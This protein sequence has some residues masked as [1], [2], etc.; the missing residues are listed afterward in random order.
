[1]SERVALIIGNND[2]KPKTAMKLRNAVHDAEDIDKRLRRFGFT[3]KLVTNATYQQM[4]R[5]LKSFQKLLPCAEAALVFFAGHGLQI[6]RE[7]FLI[8]TDSDLHDT[9]SAKCSSLSLD[10][11]LETLEKGGDATNIIMLDC[12][13]EEL[14]ATRWVRSSAKKGLAPV[15]VP[16]GSLLA[17]ST[18]PGQIAEDG[19][20]R[21]GEYTAALL[22]HIDAVDC[23]I[24]VM[25]KRVRNT[26]SAATEGRQVSWEHTSLAG[27]FYFNRSIGM[28]VD[29]YGVTA[30]RDRLFTIN[31]NKKSH[32]LIV[33]LKAYDF[34]VQNSAL[35]SF[36]SE[37]FARVPGDSLFV[38]GRNIYQA[39][40]INAHAAKAFIRDF[41]ELATRLPEEKWR[42]LLDGMLF[43]VFFDAD[44]VLRTEFKARLL[45]DLFALQ[46]Y[47]MLEKS[48]A[49][50]ANC[51]RQSA[52]SF[53][54]IP[55]T[56]QQLALNVVLA[57]K[58]DRLILKEIRLAGANILRV[59]DEDG[60]PIEVHE[61]RRRVKEK[62]AFE[63]ELSAALGVPKRLLKISYV[64]VSGR[65]AELG[66]PF[67]WTI[68]PKLS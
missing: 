23:S 33:G 68:T 36:A 62:A 17:Y 54:V 22:Q 60:E 41:H 4:D 3:T 15:Y 66:V 37:D 56:G 46:E 43:E 31:E 5:A 19:T 50:I 51:L 18:S 26:L 32:Q 2:Y 35:R 65:V 58:E 14:N 48:F 16:R 45:D 12:C 38:V 67:G 30:L 47:T 27:E 61:Q 64:G 10:R 42:A 24:E 57:Q 49:F 20:G 13:R 6:D 59:E 34:N 52:E 44:G 53:H 8:G 11:I 7:N 28:T 21:N 29:R 1:M 40:C 25:L 39:A 9:S 63:Q 55:G